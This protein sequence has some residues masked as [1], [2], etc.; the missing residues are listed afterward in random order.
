MRLIRRGRAEHHAEWPFMK[1]CCGFFLHMARNLLPA[2]RVSMSEPRSPRPA[3][4]DQC[5]VSQDAY[6]H[7]LHP[8]SSSPA[9][10]PPPHATD[11]VK[12]IKLSGKWSAYVDAVAC[13][14]DGV[15]LDGSEVKRLWTCT[16]KP[17][18]RCTALR[19]M[20]GRGRARGVLVVVCACTATSAALC[21]KRAA[22][23]LL[24]HHAPSC[25]VTCLLPPTGRLLQLHHLCA[26]P[27][28][29]RGHQGA[30]A[31]R[32]QVRR[33]VGGGAMQ[34]GPARNAAFPPLPRQ[35]QAHARASTRT[36]SCIFHPTP[37]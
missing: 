26:P 12:R 28:Q 24:A 14:E 11:D 20:M 36:R 23:L 37:T 18:V 8:L 22:R 25:M 9:P 5:I 27:Q 1:L 7:H 33:G 6:P 2:A 16:P 32:Q 29:Q 19:C 17:Q 15:P 34:E 10:P 4:K 3:S 31:Q 35:G 13:G 30:A 21:S